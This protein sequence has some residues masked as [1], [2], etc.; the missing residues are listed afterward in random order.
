MSETRQRGVCPICGDGDVALTKAG[1]LYK[2]E[3][4]GGAVCAGGGGE[5]ATD[6]VHEQVLPEPEVHPTPPTLGDTGDQSPG[7]GP[8]TAPPPAAP[9]EPPAADHDPVFTWPL[10]IRQPALYLDDAAWHQANARAAAAAAIAA[11]HVPLAEAQCTDTVSTQD[12]SGLILTYILPIEGD[13][14]G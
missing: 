12:G 8:D 4:G 5:P 1:R 10:V 13:P 14:R 3:A 11:G 7:D 2:H 9:D 6:V